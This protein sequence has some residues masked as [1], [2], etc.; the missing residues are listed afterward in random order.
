MTST[1]PHP[2][3]LVAS[4]TT[5]VTS[6]ETEAVETDP[7]T[8]TSRPILATNQ[9]VATAVEEVSTE[10]MA[11][12]CVTESKEISRLPHFT[13]VNPVAAEATMTDLKEVAS[14]M[15][16]QEVAAST[17]EAAPCAEAVVTSEAISTKIEDM[18][19]EAT[20]GLPD[21]TMT[22]PVVVDSE[23]VP[24]LTTTTTIGLRT[25][26]IT[27]V[28]DLCE[29]V[30]AETM[31]CKMTARADSMVVADVAATVTDQ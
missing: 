2:L 18:I 11:P 3:A 28:K 26:K 25:T 14:M 30:E 6:E 7:T 13:V 16:L 22:A 12:L 24:A 27:M 5:E 15:E 17:E 8:A 21:I 19:E 31:E 1:Y 29:A 4:T 9:E 23:V 10:A 20:L